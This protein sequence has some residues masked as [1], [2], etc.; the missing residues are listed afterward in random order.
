MKAVLFLSNGHG[1]DSIACNIFDSLVVNASC[2]LAFYAWPTVGGGSAYRSRGIP[3]VGP[4]NSLPSGGFATLN[5]RLMI[6]DLRAGWFST[7]WRQIWATR[8]M[9]TRYRL[10]VG[11]GDIVPIVAARLIGA[12]FVFVGSAKSSPRPGGG[13][14][15]LEKQLLRKCSLVFPRDQHIAES[16]SRA[17][18]PS[19]FVGNPMMDG[20][21]GSGDRFG[22]GPGETVVAMLPGTRSDSD[23]NIFDLL[24]GAAKAAQYHSVFS[25]LRFVF[26]IQ[27]DTNIEGIARLLASDSRTIEWR[28]AEHSSPQ[29]DDRIVLRLF[30][31]QGALA[32]LVKGLFSETLQ[33]A[34]V[35]V[36]MA[37]TANE[38]AVGLGIP[39]IAV[40]SSGVQGERYMRRKMKN[41]GDAAMLINRA[42]D[43]IGHSIASLLSNPGKRAHMAAAG[44]ARM[45]NPGASAMIAQ[46]VLDILN[47][48]EGVR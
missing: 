34:T 46:E 22:I 18:V 19:R 9:R 45:G 47:R 28:I 26:A 44:R 11:V 7:H 12:P 1:E 32:I 6:R 39:L 40:P 30:G 4:P 5:W 33:I 16:L 13:Y 17:G 29:R 20:L 43:T 14:T 31:P 3:I 38:Q 27:S 42:P 41:F 2:D 25:P 37:G 15:T 21:E 10:V 36:G 23:N 24:A 8:A 35:V 48:N